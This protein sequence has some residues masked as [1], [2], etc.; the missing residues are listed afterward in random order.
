[1]LIIILHYYEYLLFCVIIGLAKK[2]KNIYRA[3]NTAPISIEIVNFIRIETLILIFIFLHFKINYCHIK[4]VLAASIL[5]KLLIIF[6]KNSARS[7][8]LTKSQN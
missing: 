8:H 6:M 4:F 1:M 7:A 3:P 2:K 5:T